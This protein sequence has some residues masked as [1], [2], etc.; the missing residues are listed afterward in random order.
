VEPELPDPEVLP[1]PLVEPAPLPLGGVM[2][3]KLLTRVVICGVST[4]FCGSTRKM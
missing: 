2:V 3:P 4:P 1:E